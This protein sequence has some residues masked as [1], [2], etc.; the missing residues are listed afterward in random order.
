MYRAKF[1][2]E[3]VIDRTPTCMIYFDQKKEKAKVERFLKYTLCNK[4]GMYILKL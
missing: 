2:F 1:R 3:L 4:S